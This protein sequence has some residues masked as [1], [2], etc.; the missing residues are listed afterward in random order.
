[1]KEECGKITFSHSVA[2][3]RGAGAPLRSK[4]R[5]IFWG[6]RGTKGVRSS[7]EKNF[8]KNFKPPPPP[9]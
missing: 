4:K 5:S 6:K 7:I 3:P 9:L 2:D 8:S 1:L